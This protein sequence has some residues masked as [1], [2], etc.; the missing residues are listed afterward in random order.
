MTPSSQAET[1]GVDVG[2]TKIAAV[3]LTADGTVSARARRATPRRTAVEL[4]AVIGQ[5]VAEVGGERVTAV[6]VGLPGMVDAATGA[7]VFAPGLDFARAPLRAMI[8]DAVGLPVV[9][10]NDANAAAWAEYRLGA[11][12]G[13]EHQVLVTLGTGLGCGVVVAGRLL[14]GAHGFAAE[15]SHLTV[16]PLGPPC[17]CG[18]RGCWGV[19]ASGAAIARLGRQ[20][21]AARPASL[22]ARLLGDGSRGGG[23]GARGAGDAGGAA[24]D[25]DGDAQH[26]GVGS[27]DAG[28]AVTEAARGG[29]AEALDILERMGTLTGTG[30][31]ALANVFDPAVLIVGGGP[32]A[33]GDLLLAPARASFARQ[34]YSP[35]DRPAVPV[36]PA[37]FGADAGAIGA[38]LLAIE[39]TT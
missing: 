34:L 9:A 39:T 12:R 32:V 37:H 30:L 1:V 13:H 22:L 38:A 24:R 11:G 33:A 25:A 16:D 5:L 6:G 27:W 28:E 20:A 7:L 23:A 21:A 36:L 18:K 19:S 31:A 35:G 3:R 4:V 2:A 8:A 17:E 10:D 15:A 26:A 29:D 14:R